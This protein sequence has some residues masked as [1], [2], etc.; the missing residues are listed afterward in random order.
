MPGHVKKTEGPDPCPDQWLIVSDEL[1]VKLKSKPYDPKKS[2]W[3]PD[4]ATG[5]YFEGLIES[6]DGEKAT[7]KILQSGEVSI[8]YIFTVVL[9]LI[10]HATRISR[11]NGANLLIYFKSV[12]LWANFELKA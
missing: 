11:K 2:C 3:V 10:L 7:V 12:I 6:L 5:G 1:K 8:L 4:K 9:D